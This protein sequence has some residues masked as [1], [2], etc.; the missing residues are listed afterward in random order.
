M[1]QGHGPKKNILIL[2]AHPAYQKSR[3]NKQLVRA[4]TG[5]ENVRVH[6]LYEAYPDF[7]I[8]VAREQQLLLAHDIIVFQHPFYWYSAPALVK[9]WE[10]LVLEYGFAYGQGGTALHGKQWLSVISTGGS[11]AAYQPDGINRY[12]VREL[13]TPFDQTANL[14]GMGFLPPFIVHG[15]HRLNSQSEIAPY[16]Q[17]YADLL[18]SLRD[19]LLSQEIL[20]RALYLN[21]CHEALQL[22]GD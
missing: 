22:G 16:A 11:Q 4:A 10:D 6:D 3:I 19:G 12:R 15:S 2:F 20:S 9:E 5:I 7:Q 17:A 8:D 21:D 13:L 18:G 1:D 14:C